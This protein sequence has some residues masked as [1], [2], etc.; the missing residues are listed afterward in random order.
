MSRDRRQA[1]ETEVRKCSFRSLSKMLLATW[2]VKVTKEHIPHRLTERSEA[3]T[4]D[5]SG[6]ISMM[7][8]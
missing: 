3:S 6:N 7:W 8:L 1:P 5:E 2:I 4:P